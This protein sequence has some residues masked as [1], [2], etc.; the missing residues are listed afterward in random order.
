MKI[1]GS[2]SDHQNGEKG[3]KLE[4]DDG[5]D[6]V[7]IDNKFILPIPRSIHLLVDT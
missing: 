1:S 5:A 6:S 7:N 2:S 4:S 3:L